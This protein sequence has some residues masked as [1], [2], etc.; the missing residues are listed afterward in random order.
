VVL[1]MMAFQIRLPSGATVPASLPIAGVSRAISL[2]DQLV[3]QLTEAILSRKIPPGERLPSERELG[4]QFKVSRTVVREAVRSLAARGLVRVTAGRGVE[5]NERSS[6]PMAQS[7]RLLVHGHEGLDYGKVNEVRMAVEVQTAGLAAERAKP[8]DLERLQELCD[9]HAKALEDGDLSGAS[10]ADFEFH[11]ALT[12]AAGNELL[13]VMLDSISDV[14]REVRQ[15]SVA[16]PHASED[17]LKAH[18]RILKCI[19]ARKPEAARAAMI[20]HLEEA[21]RLWRLGAQAAARSDK[22]RGKTKAR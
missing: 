5:V 3:E 21:E 17:G 10:E 19:V 1:G 12:G 13:V 11:R 15:Q 20:E 7:M 4:D 2:S 14:L 9:A 6:A 16:T 18:R 22:R 8:A